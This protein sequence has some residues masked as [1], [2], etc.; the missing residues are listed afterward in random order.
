M[1][2]VASEAPREVP[3]LG[4]M[5]SPAALRGPQIDHAGDNFRRIQQR[6]WREMSI[7][8][9]HAR[10]G[11]PE[12]P[13]H[14]VERDAL[15]DQ[16][17]RERMTQVMQANIGQSAL[18]RSTHM[19]RRDSRQSRKRPSHRGVLAGQCSGCETGPGKRPHLKQVLTFG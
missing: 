19:M 3:G 8:L 6:L 12:Q 17:A 13:L 9:R 4:T 18:L 11:V 16:K 14:H 5:A 1:R 15:I 2:A 7:P 10:R